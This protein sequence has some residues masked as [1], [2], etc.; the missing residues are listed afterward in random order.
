[1]WRPGMTWEKL[2]ADIN[3]KVK[4]P[5][6]ANI[7]WMPIQTRNEMLTTGFRSVLGIKVFGPDLGGIQDVA[8]QIEKALSDLPNTRSA[9]AERTTGGYFLDFAINRQ[10]AARYG[11]TVGD[12]NAIIETA[13]GGKT[14][15]TTVE[16]R[17]RY[18]I[19]VRYARDFRED[20][21]ALKGVLVPVPMSTGETKASAMSGSTVQRFNDSTLAQIPIS[22]LAHISYK[23]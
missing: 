13:I 22:M 1:Q 4:T 19:N 6:M 11:F 16:G 18:P 9:F 10:T 12:V 20:L 14:I 2:I 17:E 21:D 5:G 23:T 8:I 15:A 3:E 7:F